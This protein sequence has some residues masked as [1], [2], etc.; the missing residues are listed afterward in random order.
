MRLEQKPTLGCGGGQENVANIQ[1]KHVVRRSGRVG[2]T[3]V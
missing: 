2:D 3:Y 1:D